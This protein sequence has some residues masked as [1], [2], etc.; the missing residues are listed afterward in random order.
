MI[1]AER[2]APPRLRV[3]PAED[4]VVAVQKQDGVTQFDTAQIAVQVIE[5]GRNREASGSD[6][7]AQ[8]NRPVAARDQG[9]KKVE[10]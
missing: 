7:D 4:H 6:I 8:C 2:M 10:R 3:A 1:V 9:L 5:Q